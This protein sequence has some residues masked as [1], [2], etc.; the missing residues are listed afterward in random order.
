VAAFHTTHGRLPAGIYELEA[1]P[2][3]GRQVVLAAADKQL[4]TLARCEDDP[5]RYAVLTVRLPVRPDPRTRAAVAGPG[6]KRPA[7]RMPQSPTRRTQRR[8][9]RQ[10]PHTTSTPTRQQPRGARLGA[11]FHLHAHAT[12]VTRRVWPGAQPRSLFHRGRAEN[13]APPR[14][15]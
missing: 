2:G 8:R 1:A 11:G 3:G 9:R 15:T 14:K 7:G 10:A 4:A 5:A 12:P 13:P 6:G